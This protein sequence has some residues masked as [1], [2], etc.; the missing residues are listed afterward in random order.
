MTNLIYAD[1]I[2]VSQ[3]T[4]CTL[5]ALDTHSHC[6]SQFKSL[7]TEIDCSILDCC[8]EDT[9][10]SSELHRGSKAMMSHHQQNEDEFD[11]G[12]SDTSILSAYSDSDCSEFMADSDCSNYIYNDEIL[13]GRRKKI[14]INGIPDKVYSSDRGFVTNGEDYLI[15]RFRRQ[16]KKRKSQLNKLRKKMGKESF[17]SR[18][19]VS[20]EEYTNSLRLHQ[21]GLYDF[22]YHHNTLFLR[23][24]RLLEFDLHFSLPGIAAFCLYGICHLCLYEVCALAYYNFDLYTLCGIPVH[25]VVIIFGLSLARVSGTIWYWLGETR[26][27]CAKFAFRNKVILRDADVKSQKWFKKHGKVQLG[28]ELVGFFLVYLGLNQ[29]VHYTILPFMCDIQYD[30]Y[31]QLPSLRYGTRGSSSY[32]QELFMDRN[33]SLSNDFEHAQKNVQNNQI[34][35]DVLQEN[36]VEAKCNVEVMCCEDSENFELADLE[37]IYR[38][39]AKTSFYEFVGYE[40]A[41]L[42]TSECSAYVHGSLALVSIFSLE[43]LGVNFWR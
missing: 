5:H 29:F 40:D 9:A 37:H 26:Y 18:F 6:R 21:A 20:N 28:V 14:T 4:T 38:V 12:K 30:V 16:F 8:G 2:L 31:T 11:D 33:A 25:F 23:F 15:C 1:D 36:Q 39:L 19:L 27:E 13:R 22:D 3:D 43:L 10:L 17:V 34:F 7:N 24:K 41:P 42:Y 35:E 32:F